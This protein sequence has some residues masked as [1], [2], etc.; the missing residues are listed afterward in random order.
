VD[1]VS[2]KDYRGS[3]KRDTNIWAP[4]IGKVLS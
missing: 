1:G 3:T 2:L 4:V